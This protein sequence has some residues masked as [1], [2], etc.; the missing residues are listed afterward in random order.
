MNTDERRNYE[1]GVGYMAMV[2][3]HDLDEVKEN[4]TIT[5]WAILTPP[6]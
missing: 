2:N 4:G 6:K 5:H 3:D 1:T